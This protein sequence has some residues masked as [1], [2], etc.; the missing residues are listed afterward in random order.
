MTFIQATTS[1]L[2]IFVLAGCMTSKDDILGAPSTTTEA[3]LKEPLDTSRETFG[4]FVDERGVQAP[5]YNMTVRKGISEL[6]PRVQYLN[7]SR[8]VLYYY[9]RLTSSGSLEP[10][11]AIEYPTYKEMHVKRVR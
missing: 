5:S 1:F 9:P 7:N 10:A 8:R 6:A 3:V 4:R 2:A 11:Y